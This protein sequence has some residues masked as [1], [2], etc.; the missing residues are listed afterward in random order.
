MCL[1][2]A[3]VVIGGAPVAVGGTQVAVAGTDGS[4]VTGLHTVASLVLLPSLL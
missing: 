4:T 2:S 1:L 3:Q